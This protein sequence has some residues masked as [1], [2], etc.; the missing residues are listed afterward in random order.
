MSPTLRRLHW[1]TTLGRCDGRT[2]LVSEGSG[3][4]DAGRTRGRHAGVWTWLVCMAATVGPDLRVR[5]VGLAGTGDLRGAGLHGV[6][7]RRCRG[8][9]RRRARHGSAWRAPRAGSKSPRHRR[10]RAGRRV[11]LGGP[12]RSR[13]A[14]RLR[15]PAGVS[16]PAT[17]V[18]GRPTSLTEPS[19]W[20]GHRVAADVAVLSAYRR[21][22][23]VPQLARQLRNAQRRQVGRGPPFRGSA[24]REVPRRAVS[25]VPSRGRCVVRLG[26]SRVQQSVPVP[27][28]SGAVELTERKVS[29]RGKLIRPGGGARRIQAAEW[30]AKAK[31]FTASSMGR[32]AT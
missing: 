31:P 17:V 5:P 21:P 11:R 19:A 6:G 3:P 23:I 8:V 28:R 7:V 20:P 29:V 13:A 27:H 26:S 16:C 25:P 18:G 2:P 32:N 30:A 14:R 9:D 4:T 10:H 12:L 24:T 22:D 1:G 15:A